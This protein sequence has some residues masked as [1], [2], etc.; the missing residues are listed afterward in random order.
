MDNQWSTKGD[1]AIKTLGD[2][3]FILYFTNEEDKLRIPTG[4]SWYHENSL[5]VLIESKGI[6]D[7]TRL[8]FTHITFW[9]QIQNIPIICMNKETGILAKLEW[10]KT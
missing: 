9:F 8:R 4:G 2:N 6:G 10:L 1:L 3:M 5:L 7:L